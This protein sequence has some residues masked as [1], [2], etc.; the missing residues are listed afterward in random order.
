[1]TQ[2]D[3]AAVEP[4]VFDAEVFDAEDL[5]AFDQAPTVTAVSEKVRA[6][7]E[8]AKVTGAAAVQIEIKTE[9]DQAAAAEYLAQVTA[10]RRA[11]DAERKKLTGPL[12]T[13]V[14]AINERFRTA[15]QPLQEADQF[16]RARL[17]EFAR[18]QELARQEEQ[19]ILA[20][21]AAAAAAEQARLQAEAEER[22]RQER[23]AAEQARREAQERREAAER[24]AMEEHNEKLRKLAERAR[25]T[26]EQ[27]PER[28]RKIAAGE[29]DQPAHVVEA[30]RREVERLDAI[31]AE[32]EAARQAQEAE[33]RR[34]AAAALPTPVAAPVVAPAPTGP[35][36]TS[37][38]SVGTSKVWKFEIV[39]AGDVPR[40]FLAVDEKLIRQ[41][42]RDGVRQIP[43]VR[44]F[45]GEQV[46][47]R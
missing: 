45:Q 22:A 30:C 39:N 14:K 34:A 11:N 42:V 13:V 27:D 47:V 31:A 17:A 26:G 33:D 25:K 7:T 24:A 15:D 8:A 28:L 40:E 10:L 36:R 18:Q 12:N 29:T 4:E 44:I 2:T 1:M 41:A 16:L 5:A 19:R 6:T 20:E 38:G 23:E 46:R 37:S 21:Q 32:Q 35:V 43:G 3:P 9:A